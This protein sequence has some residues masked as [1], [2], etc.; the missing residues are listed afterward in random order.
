MILSLV[1]WEEDD[2]I[3][4][5]SD[6]PCF[7]YADIPMKSLAKNKDSASKSEVASEPAPELSS[8]ERGDA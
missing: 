7:I 2:I 1:I 3:V 4:I 8:Y 6:I 5:D